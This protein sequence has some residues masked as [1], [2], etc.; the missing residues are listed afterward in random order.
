ME[1]CAIRTILLRFCLVRRNEV[2]LS[3]YLYTVPETKAGDD[4][5]SLADEGRS[6]VT[7]YIS[8][9][10]RATLVRAGTTA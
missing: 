8:F 3:I 5:A 10:V 6:L 2:L 7:F 4:I 1:N 9:S